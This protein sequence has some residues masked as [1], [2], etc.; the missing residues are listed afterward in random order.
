MDNFFVPIGGGNE[1]GAS[2]YFY[3]VGGVNFVIDAGIRFSRFSPY[4][5]FE[6]LKA[7]APNLDAIIVTHAHVDHCGAVHHLSA[8]YPE[9]PI[10]A[11]YETAQLLALMVEDAIKVKYLAER[12]SP[13]EWR[14]YGLLDAAL[15]RIER[16]EFFDRIKLKDLEIV[17]Y[18]A[19][20]IL[21]AASVAVYYGES[22]MLFHT[23]DLSLFPQRTVEGAVLPQE[24]AT[25]L[26]SESTYLYGGKRLSREEREEEFFRAIRR[27]VE[28]GGKVLIPV[29][30]LGRAQEMLLL[31]TEGMRSGRVPPI[32]VYV[33]GLAKEVSSIYESFLGRSFYNY[34]VQPAPTYQGLSYEEVCRENLREADCILATSGMLLEGTPSYYY[35]QLLSKS[36]K[37]AILFSG[38]MVEESFGY[39]LLH[40][41]E[42][43]K[44]FK[45][46]LERHHF[47][48]HSGREELLALKETLS[49]EKTVFV[50]GL[51]PAGR[52]KE[53]A[54]NRE[55][56]RF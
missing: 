21:G 6:L 17:F 51:P 50:H 32:T 19:G 13:E 16:R 23:G 2:C 45:C 9:T 42:L 29:F 48:A 43:L 46:R 38:Y 5:D 27:T 52:E 30:A 3:S 28:Q 26:V 36:P 24:R 56:V 55:V 20:H 35:G 33:D 15:S 10:Y 39:R 47:S 8:L 37:N 41:K 34:F 18:P 53:H 31:L 4:P 49:P 11:T 7:L 1:I 44:R 12:N 22:S 40:D 54:F 14:E 25:L